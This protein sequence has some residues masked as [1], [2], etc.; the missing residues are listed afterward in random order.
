M[1]EVVRKDLSIE[2]QA[3]LEHPD[4]FELDVLDA[5]GRVHD[6][7]VASE[8]RLPERVREDD[9]ERRT[10]A[11]VL[12]GEQATHVRSGA[13]HPKQGGAR[14]ELFGMLGRSLTSQ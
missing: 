1:G 4:D 11:I 7:R 13:D 8:T 2:K 9:D 3:R 10:G 12:L 5:D 14:P 6:S